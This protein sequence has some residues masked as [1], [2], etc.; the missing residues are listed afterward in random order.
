MGTLVGQPSSQRPQRPDVGNAAPRQ[1][2]E[3]S[4]SLTPNVWG[5]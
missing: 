5:E 3:R 1:F 4:G 2:A